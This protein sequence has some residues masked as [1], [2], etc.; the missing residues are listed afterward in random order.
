MIAKYQIELLE[1]GNI[2]NKKV[3]A[4]KKI[5]YKKGFRKRQA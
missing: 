1:S 5:K 3:A 4:D 2:K